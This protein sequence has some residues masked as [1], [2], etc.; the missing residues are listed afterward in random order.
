MI[1]YSLR[2]TS[3]DEH[4]A[5]FLPPNEKKHKVFKVVHVAVDWRAGH[6]DE[7]LAKLE[8]CAV[9]VAVPRRCRVDDAAALCA[10]LLVELQNRVKNVRLMIVDAS[11]AMVPNKQIN[12][13]NKQTTY[14][15][16]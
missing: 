4:K 12:K 14:T 7:V 16:K 10:R 9:G 11:E 1:S 5:A 6:P 2:P 3:I 8:P 13:A 15:D